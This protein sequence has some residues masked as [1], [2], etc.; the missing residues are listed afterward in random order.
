MIYISGH[1]FIKEIFISFSAKLQGQPIYLESAIKRQARASV[2]NSGVK[3][4]TFFESFSAFRI[5]QLTK[6]QSNQAIIRQTNDKK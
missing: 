3:V 5:N 2:Q 1:F 4:I 6:Q